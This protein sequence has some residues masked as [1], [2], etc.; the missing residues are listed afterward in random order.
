MQR[1]R[2]NL[3]NMDQYGENATIDQA[4]WAAFVAIR[5]IEILG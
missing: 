3:G 5:F 1:Q 2:Q 4:K